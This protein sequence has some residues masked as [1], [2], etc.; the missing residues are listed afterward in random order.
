MSAT[1]LGEG[2]QNVLVL[3]ILQAFEEHRKKGAIILIEEPEMFLHPQMQRS[4][5][6][7]LRELGKTNQIIYTTHSPHFVSVPEYREILLIRKPGDATEARTSDLQPTVQRSEKLRKE[8]DPER[9]ELFF[10][11]R[12]LLVEGDT[13][14]LALPE[15][16][17]RLN[18]DLDK[19]GS[20]IVEV[21]GKRNLE[22]FAFIAKSFDIPVGIVYD[23]DS[24]DF[25][26]D[27]EASEAQYN[28]KLDSLASKDLK[29]QV[30]QFSKKYEDEVRKI[31]GEVEYQK[32]CSKYP[33]VSKAIR[34]RLVA[35]DPDSKIPTAI[36]E[37]LNWLA[38]IQIEPAACSDAGKNNDATKAKGQ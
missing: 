23:E 1:E 36:M 37:M 6:K 38:G 20:T 32:L 25:A 31:N 14:K 22:E 11:K 3:A 12:V 9:N 13:E 19:E 30:W 28:A 29:C 5:Y 27:E 18:I 24:S 7:T 34:G 8:L 21:G 15:F 16:A 35:A 2:L 17:R 10:A 26:K 33:G 4:L